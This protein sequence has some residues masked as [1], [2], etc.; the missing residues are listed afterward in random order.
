[1]DLYAHAKSVIELQVCG[2]HN[3]YPSVYFNNGEFGIDCCCGDFKIRCL[4]IV[5]SMLLSEK[6]NK[7]SVVWKRPQ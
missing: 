5:I 7:L 2:I 1:M 3:K 4:K 6:D